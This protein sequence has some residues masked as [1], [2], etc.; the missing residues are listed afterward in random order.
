MGV[1]MLNSNQR[2][3]QPARKLRRSI[4]GMGIAGDSAG[5]CGIQSVETGYGLFQRLCRPHCGQV[6]E[7]LAEYNAVAQGDCHGVFQV[8]AHGKYGA[9]ERF[10]SM[11]RATAHGTSL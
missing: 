4:I 8:A 1:M 3:S 9:F 6:A 2:Q 10:A 5:S 11:R 7:R